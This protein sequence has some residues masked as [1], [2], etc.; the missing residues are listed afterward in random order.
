MC[1]VQPPRI[2]RQYYDIQNVHANF[3]QSV[4]LVNTF[5]VNIFCEIII[6]IYDF[7]QSILL[8][9]GMYLLNPIYFKVFFKFTNK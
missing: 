5:V 2:K 7:C 1:Y 6:N 3:F 8:W 4:V 9:F